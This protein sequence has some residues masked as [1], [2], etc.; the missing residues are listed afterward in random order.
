MY[1]TNWG[2]QTMNLSTYERLRRIRNLAIIRGKGYEWLE[3]LAW[4]KMQ[5]TMKGGETK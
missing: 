1:A 2:Q 3:K 4:M 5:E